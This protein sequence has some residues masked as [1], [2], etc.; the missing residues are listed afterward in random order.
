ML[1]PIPAGVR[2]S[3]LILPHAS[4]TP[5]PPPPA[6]S[7]PCPPPPPTPHFAFD[8]ARI[9]Q[10]DAGVDYHR[11]HSRGDRRGSVRSVE[12]QAF[13]TLVKVAINYFNQAGF[14]FT[15]ALFFREV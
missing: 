11:P 3:T 6:P 14:F 2:A 8:I 15:A 13:P 5:P 12:C 1:L 10:H 9:V 4:P 7:D